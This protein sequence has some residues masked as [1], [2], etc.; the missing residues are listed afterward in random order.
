[1][2]IYINPSVGS[3]ELVNGL[4][5]SDITLNISQRIANKL[6][7]ANMT[8]EINQSD[9]VK[10]VY[11]AS[12]NAGA[13]L[14]VAINC[15]SAGAAVSGTET[16]YCQ[17]SANGQKLAQSI[18]SRIV[19]MVGTVD[20]GIKPDTESAAGSLGVLRHTAC[21]AVLVELA[22]L[23]NA[24]DAQIL[25]DKQESFADAV[26]NGI[27]DYC[28]VEGSIKEGAPIIEP[29]LKININLDVVASLARKHESNN[30]LEKIST[31]GYGLYQLSS[32][33]KT[34]NAFVDWLSNH[35]DTAFSNYG[36]AL[37]DHSIDSEA[38]VDEWK[39]L[40]T[41]DPGNFGKLQD[42]FVQTQCFDKAVNAL[43]QNHFHLNKHSDAMKAV[44]FARSLQDGVDS[45]VNAVKQ[46][47]TK[48][49]QPNLSYVDDQ[50]FDEKIINAIYDSLPQSE[51]TTNERAD[52]IKM[53][54]GSSIL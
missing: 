43:A 22:F 25:R 8:T 17:G 16:F 9:G 12:N 40:T 21:P 20:R 42:E 48:L 2:K 32:S 31:S 53:L 54:S 49:N 35:S 33:K 4:K 37:A 36:K 52:A 13:D 39:N 41:V 47:G 45:C 46:A 28:G 34:I 19:S 1:M 24:N 27:T 26:A 7:S 30:D 50:F 14:F 23:S 29:P 6:Q 51:R 15:N 10:S 5:E 3:A 11:E 38:F 18:Q 44:V